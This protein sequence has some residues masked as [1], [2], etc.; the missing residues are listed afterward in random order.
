MN[1]ANAVSVPADDHHDT[2]MSIKDEKNVTIPYREAVR[3][4]MYIAIATTPDI[5]FAVSTVC[6]YLENPKKVH[7][8]A[9]KRFFK[10]IKGTSEFGLH[11]KGRVS[12]QIVVHSD[13]D[14]AGDI[15]NR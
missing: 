6:Q 2:S 11:F 5:A 3:S 15:D 1:E 12:I 14:F 8:N 7:W 10:Y 9:V 4:L 13:A